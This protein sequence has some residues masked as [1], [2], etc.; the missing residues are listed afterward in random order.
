[1]RYLVCIL[2]SLAIHFPSFAGPPTNNK[3]KSPVV[4]IGLSVADPCLNS[5]Y[6]N[7]RI[8]AGKVVQHVAEVSEK[9]Q[10]INVSGEAVV[11]ASDQ[12]Y[13]VR[14]IDFY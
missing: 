9:V 8:C 14:V 5:Y 7:M 13:T 2:C 10:V 4:A 11:G 3:I 12:L 1:M 6:A